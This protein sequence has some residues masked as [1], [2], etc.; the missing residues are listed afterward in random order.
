MF[1]HFNFL[2]ILANLFSSSMMK[3]VRV[4]IPLITLIN[5]TV[6]M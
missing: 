4:N 5:K 6:L 2:D 1:A 3:K